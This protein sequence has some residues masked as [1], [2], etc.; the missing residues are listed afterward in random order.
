MRDHSKLIATGSEWT[1][2]HLDV[3]DRA[4]AEHARRYRLD[5][6]PNQI[7]L[8]TSEQMLDAYSAVGLPV[9]Y[10]HWSFG[11]EF[12]ANQKGYQLSLIHI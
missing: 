8:I 2:D 10:H 6:F 4:C 11:K 1:F 7:E 9:N 12:L 5:T 3:L